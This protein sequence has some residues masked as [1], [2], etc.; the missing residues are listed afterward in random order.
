MSNKKKEIVKVKYRL[1]LLLRLVRFLGVA[2]S[3]A[4]GPFRVGRRGNG[5]AARVPRHEADG[6]RGAGGG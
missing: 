1:C 6:I 5:A 3:F 4:G 2:L